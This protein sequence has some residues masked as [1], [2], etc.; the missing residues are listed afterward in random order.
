MI[1][2]IVGLVN[3]GFLSWFYFYFIGSYKEIIFSEVK[4]LMIFEILEDNRNFM[5]G[6]D[7]F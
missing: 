2:L 7:F 5:L 4:G 3:L 6:R 1:Y